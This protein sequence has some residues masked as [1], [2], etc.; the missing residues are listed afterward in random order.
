MPAPYAAD[1]VGSLLRPPELLEARTAFAE[2]RMPSAE[3]KALE[4]ASILQVLE[5]QRAPAWTS[6]RTASTAAAA[7]APRRPTRSRAWWRST[8][9]P[10]RRI[11]DE[12]RGPNAEEANESGDQAARPGCRGASCARPA[13]SSPRTPPSSKQHAGAPWK[14]TMPGPMS[15][16]GGMFEP[17]V[18]ETALRHPFALAD[19]LA[20]DGQRRD[21]GR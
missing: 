20:G 1:H 17:G 4:D 2:G 12:W 14:I 15:M 8:G 18:S 21:A 16:A 10:I 5:M 9:R 11:F 19:D 6:S 3:F 13:A 7:G